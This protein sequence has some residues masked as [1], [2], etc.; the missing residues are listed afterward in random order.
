MPP[1]RAVRRPL[2]LSALAAGLASIPLT[3]AAL[4]APSCAPAAVDARGEPASFEWLAKTKA[5]ANWRSRV[6][7][8]RDL[9]GAYSNW[10]QASASEEICIRSP[11]G[12]VCTT[13]G[14]PCRS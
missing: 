8:M 7:A 5:R 13:R 12:F 9:G 4:A 10:A 14:I 6:R 1:S 3:A 2:V 11:R